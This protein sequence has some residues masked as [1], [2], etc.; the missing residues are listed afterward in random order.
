MMVGEKNETKAVSIF[1]RLGQWY[2]RDDSTSEVNDYSFE[3]MNLQS[4]NLEYI[5]NNYLNINDFWIYW[6][7]SF[8]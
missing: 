1:E 5:Y 3:E 7:D 6:Y 2:V 4:P 8:H